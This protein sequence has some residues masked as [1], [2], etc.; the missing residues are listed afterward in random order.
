MKNRLAKPASA[1]LVGARLDAPAHGEN[2]SMKVMKRTIGH[3]V[4]SISPGLWRVCINFPA[5]TNCWLWQEPDGLTL[6]DAAHSWD[7]G[8]ILDTI[9]MIDLPLKRIAITHAH[10][11]HAGGAAELAR[12][13]GATVYAHQCETRFLTGDASI[14]DMPGSRESR[15]L[16]RIARKTGLLDPPQI[17]DVQSV[18]DGDL[19][20][21]L[22]VLHTPG[23]TPG[24]IS[25]WSESDQSM[26]I[27]DNASTRFGILLLNFSWFTLDSERLEAS[28]DRY[29]EVKARTLLAGHGPAYHSRDAVA[30]LQSLGIRVL[31]RLPRI[32]PRPQ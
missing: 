17:A 5:S 32:Q 19:V 29:S 24:S 1:M 30:D 4:Q 20:G 7:A 10:P 14:A 12:R 6:I 23:H 31:S 25:L 8:T 11:D 3:S 28:L 21:S 26:F 13:T 22:K 15:Y 18:S 9:N 2:G 16:H 27:G